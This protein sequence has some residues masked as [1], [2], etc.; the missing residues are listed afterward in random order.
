MTEYINSINALQ[1]EIKMTFDAYF[2]HAW[3]YSG[4]ASSLVPEKMLRNIRR[5]SSPHS[6]CRPEDPLFNEGLEELH[7]FVHIFRNHIIPSLK[8]FCPGRLQTHSKDSDILRHFAVFALPANLDH[9]TSLIMEL[10]GHLESLKNC[11]LKTAV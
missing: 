11:S 9:L 4:T 10:E 6:G 5:F 8:H 1:E 2:D 3:L 7:Q